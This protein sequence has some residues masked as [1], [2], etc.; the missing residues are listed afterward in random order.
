MYSDQTINNLVY[1]PTHHTWYLSFFSTHT[2]FCTNFLHTK[3]CKLRQKI[4]DK[5]ALIATK[6]ILESFNA[7]KR[8]KLYT[9]FL[10]I[11]ELF[12]IS[13]VESFFPMI[14]C[15]MK[16]FPH[17]NVEKF[18]HMADFFS[19]NM[20]VTLATNIRYATHDSKLEKKMLVKVVTTIWITTNFSITFHFYFLLRLFMSNLRIISS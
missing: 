3:A 7:T 20:L 15:H 10:H 18:L 17:Y 11:T 19:T 9:S 1:I 8:H 4:L 13:H 6:L 14:I 5:T 12:H 2:I 16:K